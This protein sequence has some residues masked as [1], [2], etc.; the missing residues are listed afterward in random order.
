MGGGGKLSAEDLRSGKLWKGWAEERELVGMLEKGEGDVWAGWGWWAAGWGGGR[1]G[2]G[3]G[4]VAGEGVGD[5]GNFFAVPA[6]LE[7]FF[8]SCG[9]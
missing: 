7:D 2:G 3:L 9:E 5:A 6:S 8:V 4:L 1:G